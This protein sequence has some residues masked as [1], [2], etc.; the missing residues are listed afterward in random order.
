M[1]VPPEKT[2]PI[3]PLTED[4]AAIAE[5]VGE[6]KTAKETAAAM[7]ARGFAMS[8]RT[9]ESRIRDVA[10]KVPNPYR[11]TPM[12]AIKAWWQQSKQAA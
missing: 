10:N 1:I 5:M 6:G 4:E 11:L 8:V 2:S 9:V 3:N 7:V 12:A